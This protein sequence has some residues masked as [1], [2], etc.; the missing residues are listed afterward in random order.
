MIECGIR[1]HHCV[2]LNTD[3][4]VILDSE[5][6]LT[7]ILNENPLM[8]CAGAWIEELFVAEK[9]MVKFKWA[10]ISRHFLLPDNPLIF[11]YIKLNS[12]DKFSNKSSALR[13][14]EFICNVIVAFDEFDI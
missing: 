7:I 4:N 1:V 5:E 12:S 14:F 10:Y 3:P 2:R 9:I 8:L 6:G 11:L 13:F